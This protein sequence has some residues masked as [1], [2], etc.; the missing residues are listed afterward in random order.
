[1]QGSEKHR[2][3]YLNP[4]V[5]S[6]FNSKQK[7][8]SAKFS[9]CCRKINTRR[10]SPVYQRPYRVSESQKAAIKQKISTMLESG[11][12]QHSSSPR[13]C[14]IVLVKKKDGTEKFCID[15]RKL[16]AFTTHDVYPIPRID[17]TLDA[18]GKAQYFSSLDMALGYWQVQMAREDRE[19]TAFVSPSGHYELM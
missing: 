13:A 2:K 15:Y 18:L 3:F 16:S 5:D 12:I 9:A 17:E 11:V 7:E 19:K 6:P 14:P 10:A 8:A 1:M 4:L